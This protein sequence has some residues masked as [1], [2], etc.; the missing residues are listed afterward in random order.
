MFF[1][2]HIPLMLALTLAPVANDHQDIE[3]FDLDVAAEVRRLE[4]ALDS[5]SGA[6]LR[7]NQQAW[8][9]R[10]QSLDHR[11]AALAADSPQ[12]SQ[13]LAQV[14]ADI[15][16]QRLTFLAEVSP[17][18]KADLRGGWTD[19]STEVLF[20]TNGQ[21]RAKLATLTDTGEGQSATCVVNG[22][23]KASPDGFTVTPEGHADHAIRLRRL[24]VTLSIEPG[25]AL[26]DSGAPFCQPGGSIYGT[27]FPIE[28]AENLLPWLLH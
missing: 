16:R 3:R 2:V 22:A 5:D 25:Q 26:G 12:D 27:Y 4:R 9:R 24:G 7:V 20:D 13:E 10:V 15:R 8:E 23:F 17:T 19:G 11:L 21:D 6:A 28:G 1:A 14:A 18:P